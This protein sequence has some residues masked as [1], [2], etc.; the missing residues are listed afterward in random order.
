MQKKGTVLGK[1]GHLV[2]LLGSAVSGLGHPLS[3]HLLSGRVGAQEQQR[4][5]GRHGRPRLLASSH[6]FAE[7]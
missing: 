7:K 6:L 3:R 1:L 4:T 2:T 5:A